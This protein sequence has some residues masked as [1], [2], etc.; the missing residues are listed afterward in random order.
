MIAVISRDDQREIVGEFFELFKTPWEFFQNGRSYDAVIVTTPVVKNIGARLLIACCPDRTDLDLELGIFSET[1]SEGALVNYRDV[2][3]PIYGEVS[4][5]AE[6]SD[7]TP[8]LV[9]GSTVGLTVSSVD[10]TIVRMGYDL[11]EEI[12][13]LLTKGQP[14]KYAQSPSLDLHI[15]ILRDCILSAGVPLLEVAPVPFGREFIVCL[16]HDIDFAGIRKHCCDHTMWGFVYRAT[17]GAI[18]NALR[19]RLSVPNLLKCWLAVASL[20]FVFAGW[21]RD[22][23]EPFEWYL[24]VENGLPVTYFLIPFKRR[25]GEKVPSAHASRR[26]A[27]Y[28]V[29]DLQQW[30]E[31]MQT[32]GCEVGVHGLDAWHSSEKGRKEL[33]RVA[34]VTRGS[35]VGVRI[36]WLLADGN[37]P[38]ALEQAGYAYDSTCGYNETVGYRAGTGQVFRYLGTEKLLELPLHIQDGA[39]FYPQ[40]LDLSNAEAD[41]RCR[42]LVNNARTLGGVLTILWHDRSHSAERFWGAFYAKFVHSLRSLNVWFATGSQTVKWFSKRREVHFEMDEDFGGLAR[43]DLVYEGEKIQPPLTVRI[44]QP[45]RAEEGVKPADDAATS[46]FID[47][48]WDGKNSNDFEQIQK[49]IIE[50]GSNRAEARL[51][52]RV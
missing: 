49:A 10:K 3:F 23:W 8:F 34:S 27:A 18:R 21:I 38:Y 5:F 33:D 48:A 17:F 9:A 37:T 15:R 46:D 12:R 24:K 41:D 14:V 36:H 52:A 7:G 22:F 40:R 13:F 19:G 29:T 51:R 32:R 28:D 47:F 31:I 6:S 35:A 50:M 25:A 26:A 45:R 20:P 44:H 39:L 30:T 1:R 2:S 43:I 4:T 16:T 11:F 42:L